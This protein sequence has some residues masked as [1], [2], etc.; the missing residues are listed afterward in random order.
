[1][2]DIF[3]ARQPIFDKCEKVV[4]YELLYRAD[5]DADSA[6]DVNDET[7]TSSVL[8]NGVLG[9]GLTKL[10]DGLTAFINVSE[11]MLFDGT[12]ELLDPKAVVVEL[13]ETIE[14]TP[15][16]T[17][18]CEALV[19]EG[20]RLA[21]DD[22]EYDD[23]YI[24]LLRVAELVKVDVVE[25]G[26]RTPEMVERLKPY[27]VRLL[28]EKVENQVIHERCVADGFELFQGYHYFKPQTVSGRDT[29]SQSVSIIRLMNMLQDAAASDRALE[30]A[31]RSD[32]S[33]TY[34][35][36]RI[37]NSAALGGRGVQ[38]I[39]HAMRLLGRDPLYRWL[40]LL[41][42]SVGRGGGDV[43][44]EIIKAALLRGR[45]CEVLGDNMRNSVRRD[46]PSSGSLFLV[47][48]F[49]Q[50]DQLVGTPLADVLDEIDVTP[51]VR[52]ALLGREGHAGRILKTAEAYAE[53]DWGGAE[54]EMTEVG[55]NPD[56]LPGVYLDAVTWASERVLLNAS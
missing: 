4:G 24:P 10:T 37:V 27:H 8:V 39:T 50:I 15:R 7:M 56:I 1:M 17:A 45:M 46:I 19:S 55:G 38:S 32:P 47:G 16:V 42:V 31:F 25:T 29:A 14:P 9:V 5:G 23:S 33:L 18:K 3:V 2:K 20:Y 43:Q 44:V 28:A 36:L 35:L 40:C 52:A 12:V 26:E 22:F 21:L 51:E 6:R 48:L 53:A 49:A 30:E 54:R 34:K 11:E 41:L 13:L